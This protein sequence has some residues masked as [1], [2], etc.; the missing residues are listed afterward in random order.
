MNSTSNENSSGNSKGFLLLDTNPHEKISFSKEDVIKKILN[1]LDENHEIQMAK[2]I[3]DEI[4]YPLTFFVKMGFKLDNNLKI[5]ADNII[6]E[7]IKMTI[8][9]VICRILEISGFKNIFVF[10]T[11]LT[12]KELDNDLCQYVTNLK[13][14]FIN[15][16]NN[17]NEQTK[18]LRRLQE[19]QQD[20]I[21]I[22]K[23]ILDLN[24]EPIKIYDKFKI[25]PLLLSNSDQNEENYIFYNYYSINDNYLIEETDLDD[26]DLPEDIPENI[27]E[28]LEE[29]EE[30]YFIIDLEENAPNFNLIH[31]EGE[32]LDAED[33]NNIPI[34]NEVS[35]IK[36][37][38]SK[39]PSNFFEKDSL[40]LVIASVYKNTY[41]KDVK[42]SG[43]AES[44][45]VREGRLHF[46]YLLDSKIKNAKKISKYKNFYDKTTDTYKTWLSIAMLVKETCP[47]Y[48]KDWVARCFSYH[49]NEVINWKI[50]NKILSYSDFSKCFYYCF[51]NKFAS[52]KNS[53]KTAEIYFYN[54]N[55]WEKVNSTK[56]IR[57][58]LEQDLRALLDAETIRLH[59]INDDVRALALRSIIAYIVGDKEKLI[60]QIVASLEISNLEK[61]M[62]SNSS[63]IGCKNCVLEHCDGIFYKRKGMPEDYISMSTGI[64]Y[65][66]Y[67]P[68]S[69]EALDLKDFLFKLFVDDDLRKYIIYWICSMFL[70]GNKEKK[71]Y[72]LQGRGNGGKSAFHDLLSK[73]FG[74][75]ICIIQFE[76]YTIPF[77]PTKP[78]PL[79]A[80]KNRLVGVS[81]E[82]N[83]N[84]NFRTEF[85]KKHTGGDKFLG[86][87]MFK[88]DEVIENTCK[89]IHVCNSFFN[90][91]ESDDSIR[92]RLTF[93]PFD[94]EFT[95]SAPENI[96]EQ[97]LYLK[98]P[99]DTNYK[100]KLDGMAKALLSLVIDT[101]EKYAKLK[102]LVLPSRIKNSTDFFWSSRDWTQKFITKCI[103]I[104]PKKDRKTISCNVSVNKIYSTFS[105]W[106]MNSQ[107]VGN[108]VPKRNVFEENLRNKW[109]GTEHPEL[110]VRGEYVGVILKN[111]E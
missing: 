12:K 98:F 77:D 99:R 55:V 17:L 2:I 105:D 109:Y 28:C 72:V 41:I 16:F 76:I 106:Y 45:G 97:I 107:G 38:A 92:E 19:H 62:N 61:N 84:A 10:Y 74:D 27:K 21:E 44:Y 57:D 53:S 31:R 8:E 4:S 22:E 20:V 111:E 47:V 59:S 23:V 103:E 93:I 96:E 3:T 26:Y 89:L 39:I 63:I 29:L 46:G 11:E 83:Q 58:F 78:S 80:V 25:I 24:Y 5:T 69:K 90:I 51:L 110:N 1:N 52:C 7:Y 65:E 68:T 71:F 54:G 48:Y 6:T 30:S 56:E 100:S 85:I 81:Q 70:A 34:E 79:I 82:S 13:F 95:H 50:E 75:Y 49:L 60:T 73:L 102:E 15:L 40:V 32:I 108:R 87:G 86:R 91:N 67:D 66:D 36:R 42:K 88:S 43:F 33:F 9:D 64:E 18:V 35:R 14:T 101:F 104:V 37:L 94:S